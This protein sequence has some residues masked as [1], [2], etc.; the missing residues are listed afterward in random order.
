MTEPTCAPAADGVKF[1]LT[2]QLALGAMLVPALHVLLAILKSVPLT[3]VA[4]STK[5]AVPKLVSVND[6]AV[7]AP[8]VVD[9]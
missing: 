8:T 3:A 2:M 1:T 6:K 5:A 9:A 7:V 4:P